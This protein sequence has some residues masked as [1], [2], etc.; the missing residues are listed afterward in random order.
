MS[1]KKEVRKTD[2]IK[3]LR[4][5]SI[6]AAVLAGILFIFPVIFGVRSDPQI[7]QL[8]SSASVI[9]KFKEAA[10]NKA[11]VSENQVSPLAKQ[12][13]AFALYLNPPA[14][15]VVQTAPAATA[16][17]PMAPV[18][19]KF[20][21]VGISC[22]ESNPELS[23]AFI[24]EPGK[25]LHWVRQSSEVG[26]LIIEQIKND[27]VVVR[28]RDKTFE[29]AVE[30]RPTGI[31]LLEG[32][33][34]GAT[35]GTPPSLVSG[36]P[37]AGPPD[38]GRASV[39]STRQ[40]VFAGPEVS[41]QPP[42]ETSAEEDTALDKVIK[43]LAELQKN[44]R[45][46]KTGSEG[47]GD[48]ADALMEKLMKDLQATHISEEEAKKLDGLGKELEAA[49]GRR[50]QATPV[51]EQDPNLS[52]APA[53]AGGKTDVKPQPRK[54]GRSPTLIRPPTPVRPPNK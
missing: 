49:E 2:M 14:P 16:P 26:H 28:D 30:A 25:G 15:K 7:E 29:I 6:V 19:P 50:G 40:D 53:P 33:S 13:D 32:S 20:T 46:D 43:Q 23:L 41:A 27:A 8:L 24:D 42:P 47:S 45:S 54:V 38:T 37:S 44:P 10:G 35:G 22:H 1:K 36:G 5:T 34:S 31:N 48:E 39:V 18:T 11:K 17:K 52:A 21:L 12:A 9:E 51:G 4:I 3:T